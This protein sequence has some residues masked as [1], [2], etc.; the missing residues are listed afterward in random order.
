MFQLE[1]HEKIVQLVNELNKISTKELAGRMGT[2]LVTIRADI[3]ELAERGLIIKGHGGAMSIHSGINLEVPYTHKAIRNLEAK[4]KIASLASTKIKDDDVIILDSGST[5]LKIAER[6]NRRGL[7]VITNDLNVGV[8]LA[9][10]KK[11]IA[12]VQ[13]RRTYTIRL[14]RGG[15]R[16]D[17]VL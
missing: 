12:D 16:R 13:R 2:S 17:C 5:T 14:Y 6:I 8:A 11:R 10:K 3:N 9:D 4:N 1:R 15:S 7:T